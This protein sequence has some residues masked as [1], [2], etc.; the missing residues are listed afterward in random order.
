MNDSC[1]CLFAYFL[2]VSHAAVTCCIPQYGLSNINAVRRHNDATSFPIKTRPFTQL[3]ITMPDD[4]R[5]ED[6][7]PPPPFFPIFNSILNIADLMAHNPPAN[8]D[9]QSSAVCPAENQ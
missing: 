7:R 6:P 8:S 4:K 1:N 5:H 2:T 9:I 3:Q